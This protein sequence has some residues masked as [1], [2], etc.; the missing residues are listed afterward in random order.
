MSE[1]ISQYLA[2]SVIVF[3]SSNATDNGNLT[4]E[5][6][7]AGIV[8]RV[9]NINYVLNSSSFILSETTISGVKG[10]EASAGSAN[11]NGYQVITTSPIDIAHPS[12]LTGNNIALV[13]KLAYDNSNHIL[14]D[15]GM[16]DVN[17]FQGVYA[18]WMN[19]ADVSESNSNMLLLG[20]VSWDG[21]NF[22]NI[23]RNPRIIYRVD[24]NVV[25]AGDNTSL[26]N[27][28]DS[29]PITYVHRAG[30]TLY[31]SL[32]FTDDKSPSD[33]GI[34]IDYNVSSSG[35]SDI[36]I[37]S[38]RT[39]YTN[40]ETN[41]AILGIDS[42]SPYLKLG[43]AEINILSSKL[44]VSGE[45]MQVAMDFYA[46]SNSS[47]SGILLTDPNSV[48]FKGK[49][50]QSNLDMK[51]STVSDG[52]NSTESLILGTST[53]YVKLVR[54]YNSKITAVTAVSDNSNKTH[55]IDIGVNCQFDNYIYP[56]SIKWTGSN[57]ELSLSKWKFATADGTTTTTIDQTGIASASSNSITSSISSSDSNS[58]VSIS[59]AGKITITNKTG[60]GY[61]EF[62][63]S[64]S[65][66][67][68]SMYH[69]NMDSYLNIVA[70][71]VVVTGTI[72][73][74]KVYNATYNDYAD[75]VK[76]DLSKKYTPGDII[77]KKPGSNEYTLSNKSNKRLVVGV[78][79]D[80]Y[81]H[82]LG[83]E[84]L[85]NME[86]NQEK[87]VPIAVA[88]NVRVKVKGH[89]S[90]GDLITVSYIDGVGERSEDTIKDIGTIVGKA[91]EN[92]ISD[93]VERIM[94]QV[95]LM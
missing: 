53:D 28:I 50:V 58:S 19:L 32:S 45:P 91:L 44:T 57:S 29:L 1:S 39:N 49:D 59:N 22:S 24:P 79:S 74:S 80:T 70:D 42:I 37:R 81:G 23:T 67:V 10:I 13:L 43:L 87:Y 9:T 54:D 11:I 17:H 8:T 89:I 68:V 12:A 18:T 66:R 85:P 73:G 30:D 82:V 55:L 63:G 2:S 71:G 26:K 83:G 95:S 36:T 78:Y 25:M 56:N 86:D 21:T 72:T 34:N 48:T 5:E 7:M 51:Y 31:G 27:L 20:T 47:L 90:E 88:G 14:G 4:L 84:N 61:L 77:S 15:D 16:A 92:K 69:N 76:K 35:D 60:K 33:Y 62:D 41:L 94:V 52:T 93:G 40:K 75:F 3:P 6:N 64:D 46:D 65:S 38:K